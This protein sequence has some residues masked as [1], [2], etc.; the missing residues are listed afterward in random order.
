MS[1]VPQ[2]N[3]GLFGLGTVGGSVYEILHKNRDLIAQKLGYPINLKKVCEL[4][5]KRLKQFGVQ[6]AIATSRAAEVLDDPEISI[7]VEL[8]GD[9]PVAKEVILKALQLG[10]H[11]V[12]ANKAC[13][14]AH[15]PEFYQEAAKN[16]VEILFEAA[17]AGSIPVLR[18]IREGFVADKVLSILG[19]I[20]G[21]SNYILT[22]MEEKKK[23]FASVLEEA[24]KLGYAEANPKADIEGID[25]AHKLTI[26]A[27]LAYG[28]VIPVGKV[29]TEGITEITPLDFDMAERFGYKIKLLAI[30]KK[31]GD[32]IEVRVHP[33]MIPNGHMLASVRGVFN[34]VMLRG[35]CIGDQLFYGRGAGGG[36]TAAAVVGDIV[37]IARNI[38]TRVPG[39]PPL[40]FRL[41]NVHKGKVR[42]M[43][44][45]DSE[46]Y[47]RFTAHDKPGVFAKI[48]SALGANGISISAVYQHGR[49]EG[50]EVPIVV[51]THK[52]KEKNMM[53]ALGEIDK[54]SVVTKKTLLIRIES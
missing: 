14:A 33:T 54:L 7:I 42:S 16:E 44:D 32:E 36:P 18:A 30:S 50:K 3:I 28:C 21:T 53:K 19:I 23:D 2:I 27:A 17:V 22:E 52:A 41:E 6:Q 47:L 5:P 20:N 9:K 45:I 1:H 40:G 49:E 26:L 24:Q 39:V 15:G 37:E 11:V 25:S 10:K 12:T 34:A 46:Y 43:E 38:G 48:A 13:L 4:D 51:M 31:E 29:T 8:I 35:E